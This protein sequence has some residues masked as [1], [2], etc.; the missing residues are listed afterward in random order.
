MARPNVPKFGNWENG[1]NVPYTLYFDKA[2]EGRGM[3][4]MINPNDPQQNP[5]LFANMALQAKPKSPPPELVTK[6][7]EPIVRGPV[8]PTH[9]RRKSREKGDFSHTA[10]SPARNENVIWRS[11]HGGGRDPNAVRP[12]RHSAE[13]RHSFEKSPLHPHYQAKEAAKVGSSSPSWE[14]KSSYESSHGTSERSRMRP[15][16]RGRETPDRAVPVPKFGEWE[17]NPSSAAGYTHIFNK[18]REERHSDSAKSPH[19]VYEPSDPP[20]QEYANDD[21]KSCC[22]PWGRK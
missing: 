22:F 18:V 20:K 10:E 4:K 13:Y 14:V 5:K 2:R 21:M 11:A 7:E 8:R 16:K 12:V 3:G 19:R 9:E 1:N 6:P 17:N 15:A